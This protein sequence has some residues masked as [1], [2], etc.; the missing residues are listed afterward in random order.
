MSKITI[1][2]CDTDKTYGQK[3][4]EW[5]SLE[6]GGRVFGS[7]FSTLEGF[8]EFQKKG[9]V[10]IVLLGNGFW[11]EP[12]I[13]AQMKEE[14]EEKETQKDTVQ[15][16]GTVTE[17]KLQKDQTKNTHKI[18]WIYL[19]DSSVRQEHWDLAKNFPVIGKYQPASRIVREI[20]YHY[21][22]LGEQQETDMISREVLGVYSPEHSIW[23]TPFALTLA[24]TLGQKEKVLYVNFKECAGFA[25]WLQENYPRDLLD[26]MYL[27]LTSEGNI[28]DCVGSAVYSMEN[29]D[30]IPPADDSQCLGEVSGQDYLQFVKLLADK[31]GYEVIILD[32]GMMVSGFF[33]LLEFCSKVYVPFERGEL[34]KNAWKHFK[35]IVARQENLRLEEKAAY[36]QLPD[37]NPYNCRENKI[38]QWIWGELGD[39]A[40]Q[41]AGVQGGTD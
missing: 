9:R 23:Q 5:I 22:K 8:L 27:C 41:I 33:S 24:Q 34:Q 37:M 25:E 13:T 14:L 36:F 18:L 29:F 32:F 15:K 4:G 10:D 20:F 28:A 16:K 39:C 35:Q 30:Y 26:V 2:V 17:K 1:A 38:Q 31:S 3:L 12:A 6:K 11:D 19:K 21:Q 40:R 7:S